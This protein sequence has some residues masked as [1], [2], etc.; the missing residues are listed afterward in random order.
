VVLTFMLTNL[1][2]M[3]GLWLTAGKVWSKVAS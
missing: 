3:L 1:G 2:S